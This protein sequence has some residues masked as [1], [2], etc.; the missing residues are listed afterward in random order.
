MRIPLPIASGARTLAA[1]A[2]LVQGRRVLLIFTGAALLGSAVAIV[3]VPALLGRI[4]DLVL[5]GGLP[6]TLDVIALALL[7]ALLVRAVLTGVGHLLVARLGEQALA[8][9]RERVM[10]RALQTPLAR[11]EQAGSG[12]LVQRTAGDISVVSE[13]I[14][15]A[16][17]ML[18]TA[19][20][21]VGLTLVGLTLLDWRLGLAGL[22]PLPIWIVATRWYLKVSGPR[23]AAQQAAEA[24]QTQTL[25]SSIGGAATVRAFRL[26]RRHRKS[27]EQTTDDAVRAGM[28]AATVSSQYGFVLNCAEMIGVLSILLT[29][30]WLV[31]AD[32]VTVGTATAAALY[33]IRLFSPIMTLLY[34]LDEAQ[35]AGAA[36]GRMVGVTDL[37]APFVPQHPRVPADASVSIIGL[38]HAYGHGPTVLFDVTLDVAPGE[39]IAVVGASGAGKTTLG[40]LVAGIHTPTEGAVA[41]GGAGFDQLAEP[42]RHVALITQEVHLFAGTVADNLRLASPEATDAQLREALDRLSV[43]VGLDTEVG[44]SAG[45][46]S[47]TLA[48]QLALARLLL[49]DPEVAVLDEA[50]AE[51]GSAGARAL[52]AASDVALR[53]R[54]AL[55]IAHRLTQAVTADRIVVLDKGRIVEKGTHADL[56]AAGGPYARLWAVWRG[57]RDVT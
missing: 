10:R 32:A 51:A 43:R 35:A 4:V 54:T 47:A 50:T 40:A 5:A 17:P 27:L 42:R 28:K 26:Q 55:V 24:G 37:P 48:Q 29:G 3:F 18:V 11:I 31:R 2:E 33:F 14:R 22:A 8:Q 9:L 56:A 23:Y 36:L 41:I 20:L 19:L 46:I 30:F 34:L 45:E 39:R 12:D 6:G 52:E 13:A 57:T 21:D 7:A 16:L 44:E 1:V 49:A 38:G 25:I 15:S 53:N